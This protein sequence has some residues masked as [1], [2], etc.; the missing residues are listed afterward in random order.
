[1][2]EARQE[3]WQQHRHAGPVLVRA[4]ALVV[5]LGLVGCKSLPERPPV[6]KIVPVPAEL[7]QPVE[8]PALA[9]NTNDD[10]VTWIARLQS[11]LKRANEQLRVIGNIKP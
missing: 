2:R 3:G 9:G 11:A 1:M 5:V 7:T 8:E 4:L 10:L 6:V